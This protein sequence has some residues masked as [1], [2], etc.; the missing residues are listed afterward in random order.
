MSI[1]T[2]TSDTVAIETPPRAPVLWWG[3]AALSVVLVLSPMV[4]LV[5]RAAEVTAE[6]LNLVLVQSRALEYLAN[7]LLLAVSVSFTALVL[8][9]LIAVGITRAFPRRHRALITLAA[10][11]L[12]IP[13]YLAA[14]GWLVVEPGLSGFVPAWILLSAVTV[15]YVVL[16]VVARLRGMGTATELVART[17][18]R[19]AFHAF[20]ETTWPQIRPAALAG[21][22]LVFLYTVSDFGLPALLRFHT[23]TWGVNAAYAASFNRNQAAVL[24]LLLVILAVIAVV[25]E[26]SVRGR[27][28]RVTSGLGYAGPPPAPFTRALFL[29][30]ILAPLAVGILVPFWGLGARLLSA[31]TLTAI[32]LPRLAEAAGWTVAVSLAAAVSAT[33]VAL[34]LASL[35]ARYR[36]RSVKVLESLGYLSH[37]LP[38]IVLGLALVFLTLRLLPAVYQTLIVLVFGYTVLFASKSLGTTRSAIEGVRPGLVMVARTLGYSPFAAWRRVT[39]PL[40][41][42]GIGVGAL[43]VMIATMKELPATL[44]LRPT[45]VNTLATELWSRTTALEYGAAAPYAAILVLMG[46]I[47]AMLLS[48]TRAERGETR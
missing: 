12:A 3:V 7:S 35:A 8:G 42:P 33:L 23:L 31:E 39:L 20:R 26:R 4:Y 44:I 32:D 47:P 40:A 17:L 45:G 24:A 15:P 37:G 1:T 2:T 22:L 41:L 5:V 34:P 46:A 25:G 13:S 14:Y 9:V 43:L 48:A 6:E 18:G 36:G 27:Q 30:A 29:G 16:P 28:H 19:N 38:G 10:L 21:G 11:P